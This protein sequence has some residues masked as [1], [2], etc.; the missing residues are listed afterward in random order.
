MPFEEGLRATIGW[1]RDNAGWVSRV[2]SGE[3]QKYYQ[4][5]YAHR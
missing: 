1:Y 2:K 5:N 4:D 3:Y